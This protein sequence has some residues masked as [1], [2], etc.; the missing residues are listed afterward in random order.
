[1]HITEINTHSFYV[2]YSVFVINEHV[3]LNF[4]SNDGWIDVT[5]ATLKLIIDLE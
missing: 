1:M 5:V 2:A 4:H 3:Q